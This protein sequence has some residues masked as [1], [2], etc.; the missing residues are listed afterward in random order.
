MGNRNLQKLDNIKCVLSLF[1]NKIF[2]LLSIIS[3][4][5]ITVRTPS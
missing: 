4:K 2:V 1:L 3:M 5:N